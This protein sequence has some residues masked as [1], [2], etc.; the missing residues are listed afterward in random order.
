MD[1]AI[2]KF[3]YRYMEYEK[4]M[5]KREIEIMFPNAIPLLDQREPVIANLEEEDLSKLQSSI[6][7][8]L[9]MVFMSIKVN[10][11]LRLFIV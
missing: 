7:A 6:L 4:V 9:H 3:P 2:K 1:I 8:I 5:M 10:S 11:I